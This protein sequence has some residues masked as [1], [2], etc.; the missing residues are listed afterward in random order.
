MLEADTYQSIISLFSVY[1][2]RSHPS[3]QPSLNDQVE[4]AAFH[5][6]AQLCNSSSKG[7]Q[8]VTVASGFIHCFDR[9]LDLVSSLCPTKPES[10][11]ES[12]GGEVESDIVDFSDAIHDQPLK[13]R[14][15]GESCPLSLVEAAFTILS[16]IILS[17]QIQ[18]S[19]I[20]DD[21]F[22]QACFYSARRGSTSV[23]RRS[24]VRVIARLAHCTSSGSRL[25][26][27][28]A[29]KVLCEMLT[30]YSTATSGSDFTYAGDNAATL[31]ADG[32]ICV[33]GKL[34]SEQKQITISEISKVYFDVLRNRSLSKTVSDQLGSAKLAY[35][36]TRLMLVGMGSESVEAAFGSSIIL[37]MVGTLQWR[38][39][40][41]T[42]LQEDEQVYWDASA[43]HALQ[44]LSLWLEQGKSLRTYGTSSFES[45][46]IQDNIWMVA[47]PGKAPRK[48]VDFAVA[49]TLASKS[50]DASARLHAERIYTW[51]NES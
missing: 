1:D 5:L 38:Y 37:P 34:A 51:L 48:A 11:G 36:L 13:T 39:D 22:I 4:C 7:R 20:C 27:P 49:V 6:L 12:K 31:A 18:E 24:A 10:D 9:A 29:A 17:I 15:N 19:L 30:D 47:R 23:L 45:H 25:T 33:F 2:H 3:I 16:S 40:S 44:I 42:I 41:K 50:A 26:A 43:T 21:T 28:D 35:A 32:L 46:N 8:A 14:P